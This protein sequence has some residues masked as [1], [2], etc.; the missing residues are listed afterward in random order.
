MASTSAE[1]QYALD[2]RGYVEIENGARFTEP[3]QLAHLENRAIIKGAGDCTYS[4]PVG[5]WAFEWRWKD[6]YAHTP[7]KLFFKD[8]TYYRDNIA[9]GGFLQIISGGQ[10]P[11]SLSMKR[12]FLES[13]ESHCID[14]RNVGYCDS[15]YFQD[16]RS[17]GSSTIRWISSSADGFGWCHIDNWT[18]QSTAR[19]G[20]SFIFKNGRNVLCN[21]LVD[22]QTAEI[23][24]VLKNN[25]AGPIY[26]QM[27]NCSGFNRVFDAF[28][29]YGGTFDDL[30]PNCWA[31]EIRADE[32]SGSHNQ[33]VCV[34]YKWEPILSGIGTGIGQFHLI[35]G[36][37][38]NGVSLHAQVLDMFRQTE[39]KAKFKGKVYPITVRS[40]DTNEVTTAEKDYWNDVVADSFR[41]W[42]SID[43]FAFP[44]QVYADRINYFGSDYNSAYVAETP[45][46]DA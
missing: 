41:D 26:F 24:D 35:G 46:Y 37:E 38:A 14:A 21:N 5:R 12:C 7:A 42:W 44:Y 36:D 28:H 18:H 30:A 10:A 32:T 2:R 4:G 27:T 3:I 16:M 31:V 19:V 6:S 23:I 39:G 43:G 11:K 1:I 45:Q 9:N 33:H 40:M 29:E 22:E 13:D 15:L 8:V 17:Q 34:L 20:T 25:W